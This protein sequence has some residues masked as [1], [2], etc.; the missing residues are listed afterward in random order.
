[1]LEAESDD[2]DPIEITGNMDFSV[3]GV[4]MFVVHPV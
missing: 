1:M 3:W 2:Y 4:V